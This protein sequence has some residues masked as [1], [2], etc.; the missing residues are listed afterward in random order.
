MFLVF[1]VESIGL[2]G[3]GFSVGYV[4]INEFGLIIEEN[5]WAIPRNNICSGSD[6]DKKWVDTNVPLVAPTHLSYKSLCEEFWVAWIRL[7]AQYPDITMWADCIFPVEA[8]F[9]TDCVTYDELNRKWSAPYPLFD[10]GT[11]L[12][13]RGKNPTNH[14]PRLESELPAH[15]P[16]AD[17]KQS[18]RILLENIQ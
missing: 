1:D 12:F 7:K 2:Y 9:L 3:T 4:V 16:L 15:N 17:A 11:L 18:A 10:I 5:L 8:G 14:Y 6:E 13:A